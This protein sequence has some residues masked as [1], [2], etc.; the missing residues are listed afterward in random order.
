MLNPCSASALLA[1]LLV[2]A[3]ASPSLAQTP[4][5]APAE[6]TVV[7][8][9]V[10]RG[11]L[12]GPAWWRVTK[13]DSTVFVLGLPEALPK[14]LEWDQSVLTRRLEGA[15]RLITPPR[16]SASLNIFELPKLLWD[17]GGAQRAKTPLSQRL[18]ESLLK[19]LDAAAARVGRKG[20]DYRSS[21]TWVAGFRLAIDHDRS[22]GMESREPLHAV[23][24]AAKR[25]G[26]KVAPAHVTSAKAVSLVD[27]VRALPE[28]SAQACLEAA[29]SNVEAGEEGLR[30]TAAAWASGDLR[31]VLHQPRAFPR[32]MA[33]LKSVRDDKKDAALQEVEAVKEALAQPGHSVAAFPLRSLV[34][35]GG[36]LDQLREQGFTVLAP[37]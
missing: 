15:D 33:Q 34:V 27:E 6:E 8:A 29:V 19:R 10:I 7:E 11:K 13:G 21:P 28:A 37:E 16:L 25:A 9:L 2:A 5:A 1:G 35:K 4:A 14:N 31:T 3:A 20:D 32:C 26:V 12:P 24:E 30:A 18:P 17:M 23:R 36:V 22:V